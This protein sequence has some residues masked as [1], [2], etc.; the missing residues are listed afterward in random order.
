M[1]AYK[2]MQIIGASLPRAVADG[3]NLEHRAQMAMASCF[4]GIAFSN[5]STNLAHAAGRAL[6]ARFH[7]PHGLSVALLL[8][9][10]M[11]FGLDVAEKRYAEIAVALGAD[12][13]LPQRTLAEKAV[14]IVYDY[15]NA[16]GVWTEARQRY[17]PDPA[18]FAEAVPEMVK[19]ALA[20]NGI[21]TNPRVPTEKDIDIVF[22]KL[23]AK[24]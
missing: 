9:F 24:L 16:F 21:L 11:E 5:A 22:K 8:P 12:A 18:A 13:A 7:V 2:A 20:G 3:D 14:S 19:N 10:V 1:Y 17:L 15:N 23:A 6:G 4:A